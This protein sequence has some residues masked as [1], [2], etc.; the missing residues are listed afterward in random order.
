MRSNK[1]IVVGSYNVDMTV[2]VDVFP[3]AGETVIGNGLAYGHGG[4]GANQAVAACLARAR[5]SLLAKV[6]SDL[7]G[8]RAIEA[9]TL[10]GV[11]THSIQ[12]EK[13]N[14]PVWHLLQWIARVRITLL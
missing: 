2:K 6:G 4:K 12:K 8:K 10:K 5:T 11:N 9:L 1:V 3:K 13:I 14:L 7:Y